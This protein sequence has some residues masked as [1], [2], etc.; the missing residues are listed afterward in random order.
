MR[1]IPFLFLFTINAQVTDLGTVS[2]RRAIVLEK[3]C[4]DFGFFIV[5]LLPQNWPTNVI[6]IV[7]TNEY[8]TLKDLDRVPSGDVVI[9]V[10][11][12]CADGTE[13]PT[14]VF[15]I[16]VR[17]Y[18]PD[19]VPYLTK[20]QQ[21]EAARELAEAERNAPPIP[22]QIKPPHPQPLPGGTNKSYPVEEMAR[23]FARERRGE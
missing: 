9:E 23:H 1:I 8:L 19:A 22:G 16:D 11:Q 2:T 14:S 10:K 5:H 18:D 21:M 12:I 4:P 7:K 15:K 13:G 3:A 17:R 20:D 6:A